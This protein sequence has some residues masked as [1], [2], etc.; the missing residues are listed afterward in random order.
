MMDDGEAESK[1]ETKV[2]MFD[3]KKSSWK[4]CKVKMELHSQ[5][6]G[7]GDLFRE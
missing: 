1:T 5:R 4:K 2:P 3:G 6:I 7:L